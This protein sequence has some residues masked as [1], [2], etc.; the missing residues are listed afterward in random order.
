MGSEMCIRDRLKVPLGNWINPTHRLWK[1]YYS[2]AS[3]DLYHV[4][5]NTLVHYTPSSGFRFTRSA[6]TY[7][8]SFEEPLPTKMDHRSPISVTGLVTKKVVKLSTGLS[9][10]TAADAPMSFWDFLYSWGGTWMWKVIEPGTDTPADVQWMVDGLRN[11]SL[12]WAIDG[13]YD[14]KRASDLCG[15]GWMVFCTKTGFR[16]TGAFW[17]H[18]SSASSYRAELLGL[19][20]LHLFAQALAVHHNVT[21]WKATLCCDNKRALKVSS[22]PTGRIRPS[23]KCAD[24]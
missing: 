16:L 4:E 22:C 18:S 10:A 21:G 6:R 15:V 7:H 20:A 9:L 5:A 3:D 14:R 24:I 8:K 13:S 17:E 19:C 1:W 11:G 2:A 23:A 12:I